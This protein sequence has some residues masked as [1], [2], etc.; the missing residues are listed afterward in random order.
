MKKKACRL[1][2]FLLATA[3]VAV[4]MVGVA[5][6]AAEVEAADLPQLQ[7]EPGMDSSN[8]LMNESEEESS[9]SSVPT[10]AST[11]S[12]SSSIDSIPSFSES[13]SS[14]KKKKDILRWEGSF[15]Q[16]LLFFSPPLTDFGD[17]WKVLCIWNL[18]GFALIYLICGVVAGFVFK[19][20]N[21]AI[22]IPLISA[23][24]GAIAGF[25]CGAIL[26]NL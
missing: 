8:W 13:S 22:V 6:E 15:I 11:S 23:I 17:I 21:L 1:C 10:A 3:I 4:L 5:A 20:H 24:V 7:I 14:S 25:F 19:N 26:C 12:S 16:Q 18:L 9:S 2:V